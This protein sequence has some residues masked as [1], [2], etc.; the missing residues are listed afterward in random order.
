MPAYLFI[1]GKVNNFIYANIP[2]YAVS[3]VPLSVECSM[4]S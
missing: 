4:S 2:L 1:V 3:S